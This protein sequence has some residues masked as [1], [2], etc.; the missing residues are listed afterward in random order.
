MHE[1]DWPGAENCINDVVLA[2]FIGGLILDFGRREKFVQSGL[3]KREDG[4]RTV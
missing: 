2:A 4:Q 3:K 1:R